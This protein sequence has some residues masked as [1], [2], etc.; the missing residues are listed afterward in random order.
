MNNYSRCSLYLDDV[1][2]REVKGS[3]RIVRVIRANCA[4]LD[5]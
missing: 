2:V 4:V 5:R 3:N 1:I